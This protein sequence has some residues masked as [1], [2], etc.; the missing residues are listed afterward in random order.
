MPLA[1][2][3]AL[4]A[5][6]G[7]HALA[8]FVPDIDLSAAQE[9]PAIQAE[10]VPMPKT[11]LATQPKKLPPAKPRPARPAPVANESPISE[12]DITSPAEPTTPASMTEVASETTPPP[13][14]TVTESRMPPRGTIRYRV[15]RGEQG[16]ELGRSTQDWELI[17]GNYRI[18]AV[19]E[20]TGLA[21]LI[22]PLVVEMESRGRVTAGGLQPEHFTVR[23]GGELQSEGAE[24]DWTRMQVKIGGKGGE[25]GST[26]TLTQGAQDLL[27]FNYH[28]GFLPQHQ[29]SNSLP[30]ATG[31]KYTTYPL[32]T[33]GDEEIEIPAGVF[34]TLHLRAPGD[35]TTELWLAYDYLLLP[36]KIRHL[37]RRGDSFV[38]VAT[39]IL[40]SKK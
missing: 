35:N 34:R 24:F 18:T 28:L 29:A 6:L 3:V 37:D 20:T 40:M 27:S 13:E 19:T 16:F 5:S 12:P 33:V 8:L 10:L 14:P 15:D 30:I 1:L 11:R 23:R 38:Q 21:W 25:G 9:P 36:V 39:E 32:E 4:A 22:K 17:D 26:H 31:R 7:A 2:I